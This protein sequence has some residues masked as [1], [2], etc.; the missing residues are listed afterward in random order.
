MDK[1]W[2]SDPPSSS[3]QSPNSWA[4]GGLL[5]HGILETAFYIHCP[6]WALELYFLPKQL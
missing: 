5:G 3:K 6:V 1:V 4:L 2:Q